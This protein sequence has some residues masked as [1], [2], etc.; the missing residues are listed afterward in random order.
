MRACLGGAFNDV[1]A[2]LP[3]VACC[4]Q[5]QIEVHKKVNKSWIEF[6]SLQ[7]VQNLGVMSYFYVTTLSAIVWIE[8]YIDGVVEQF[9][10]DRVYIPKIRIE[11]DLLNVNALLL[12]RELIIELGLK[13]KLESL[14]N[15]GVEVVFY[16]EL[17]PSTS[18]K[19][20]IRNL[21]GNLGL[22]VFRCCRFYELLR[23]VDFRY[24]FQKIV[25]HVFYD[26]SLR[27]L[28]RVSDEIV[29]IGQVEKHLELL[30]DAHK[31][32]IKVR[33]IG[34]DQFSNSFIKLFSGIGVNE[35]KL[36][37]YINVEE[38]L[39]KSC[40]EFVFLINRYAI[41]EVGLL[42]QSLPQAIFS[43]CEG[44]PFMR[45]LCELA[46]EKKKNFFWLK[47]GALN[48]H[49]EVYP[50]YKNL[51]WG[52]PGAVRLVLSSVEASFFSKIYKK[53][54]VCLAG[55][56][57]SKSG[58]FKKLFSSKSCLK[59]LFVR[60]KSKK[61]KVFL[62]IELFSLDSYLGG[63]PVAN[64]SSFQYYE[65]LITILNN[66]PADQFDL[67]SNVR[68]PSK[69]KW[70]QSALGGRVDFY[71]GASWMAVAKK[72]DVLLAYD[73]SII[74]ESANM[75][76]PVLI[77]SPYKNPSF[78]SILNN[79]EENGIFISSN[80]SKLQA[81][82]KKAVK[83]SPLIQPIKQNRFSGFQKGTLVTLL[84]KNN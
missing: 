44:D 74:L 66:L 3:N 2:V 72:C 16:D 33:V 13:R 30:R 80:P 1:S 39:Q 57:A 37:D 52:N 42:A 5:T 36:D 54:I 17:D 6:E 19:K 25:P 7:D 77:F 62:D 60:R 53:Q 68:N 28:G 32:L 20:S 40:L 69:L 18:E 23:L 75:G 76:L 82:L 67:L 4:L 71:H 58:C 47:E 15:L 43:D 63:R 26:V 46:I 22:L 79:M 11:P 48:M 81:D 14:A 10:P 65:R 55:Y 38:L 12:E 61:I 24:L 21:F 41:H 27:Q 51:L 29:L 56:A 35:I 34:S 9:M 83:A 70:I 31:S 45:V 64:L 84:K 78:S 8:H 73:S 49:E 59:Q 50:Y